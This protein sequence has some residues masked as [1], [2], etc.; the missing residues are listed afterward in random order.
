MNK[1]DLDNYI[2][3]KI[4]TN[5]TEDIT[6]NKLQDVLR[7]IN[8]S[9]ENNS[10]KG[11]P[12][13]YASLD[14]TG[15]V[16]LEQL[17]IQPPVWGDITGDLENQTDLQSALD[18]KQ[19]TLTFD[20]TPTNGSDNPVTSNGVYDALYL[21]E[22]SSNKGI[23]NGYAPLN[24]STKIDS[25]YLPSY[26]DDVVEV[27]N[28]ASLPV[29]GE[30]GK[31]YVTIDTGYIYRWSGSVY[32]KI[33]EQIQSDYTQTNT[34]A[35]DYIKN[36]PTISVGL[37]MPS[38]FNVI[39]SPT[40]NGTLTVTG[41]GTNSQYVRGDGTLGTSVSGTVTSVGL[42]MPSAFTVSNSPII[43]NGNISVTGAG[44]SS[45]YVRG[46]GVLAN[47]PTTTGGGSSVAYYL[48]G[49]VAQGTFGG[50][51]Y[52][53]LSKTPV[54]GAG[55]DFSLTNTT[56]YIAEFITNVA[57][58]S[59]LS[60]PTGAWN[61]SLYFS[62]SNNTG[63]PSFYIELYKYDG[64]TFTLIGSNS[65]S[66][67]II[68]NGT[69]IDLYTTSVAVPLTTLTITDRLAVRVF[70]NTNGNRTI[71]LHTED[72]HLCEII[73]TFSTGLN[74]IN[75]LTNQVQYLS[76]G[77]SGTDFAI[78]S[79]SDTHTF[80][81][82][83]ASSTK[84][85]KLSS[86]DWS[87]FNGKV[88]TTRSISTSSPLSGGG[89]LSAD[90]TLSIADAAADGTTK[91][92]ATF[93]ASDFNS[94]SGVISIDYTN[95]QSASNTNKGFLTSADWSTFNGKV[96][97]SLTISTTS[98]LSGGGD[99]SANRT[100]SI[101]DAAADGTTKGAATFTA[102]DFNSASGVISIDY[103][104][105]QAASAS[106]KGFLTSTDFTTF[107]GK[108]NAIT[109]TTTGTTG[110]STLVGS[111]L[112]IPQYAGGLVNFTEAQNTTSPN[113][114]VYVDSL[115]AIS[116]VTNTDF[117]II[118]KG[119]GALLAAVPDGTATGGNKRGNN[120]IDL[121]MV[122]TANTMVASGNNAIII[123]SG[124]TASGSSSSVIGRSNS[125]A[126]PDSTAVGSL[127]A[128]TGAGNIGSVAIGYNNSVSV[129]GGVALGSSNTAST[130]S[131]GYA[132]AV[133]Q[134]N[135]A[136]GTNASSIGYSNTASGNQSVAL[137]YQN[138]S[139]GRASV[140]HGSWGSSFS[141][142]ERFVHSTFGYV[143]GDS[144]KSVFL[145]SARTTNNTATTLTASFS[146]VPTPSAT[147]Q[148][149]LQNNNS[150]R[151]KGSI[152]ARQSGSTNTSAWD[153]DGIIQRGTTAASTTLLI[154]NV[155]LVQN[156]PAW[157]MP[158]LAADTTLGCLRVQVTG[159]ATTNIQW[160]CSI[161]TTEVIYA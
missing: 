13:G 17:P 130:T 140:V 5:V 158:T 152:I 39:G 114:T 59:L 104:N 135:T 105:G 61:F 110:A 67:E 160:T 27:A 92:A 99:L 106:N 153:I 77:T 15:K 55:T 46:D 119:T 126:S 32:V 73:T 40:S 79:T 1:N 124:S 85:G 90:R 9:V 63:N 132:V 97:T 35:V 107:N 50:N 141:V 103:T 157:G 71:T 161:E 116:A 70:V 2:N 36:K 33:A 155:T 91:G 115:S 51:A 56:G 60:I 19:N 23:A 29:T 148:V 38:A 133:G 88:N 25:T 24:S 100:L 149:T 82:P 6:G 21:K 131:T 123:G 147:N 76:T 159:V 58:P 16:P 45:Q 41:A 8:G 28:Y 62:S 101:S 154:S 48:N 20:T 136:S 150:F 49:S 129:N 112:N 43:S 52:K 122:R 84:T 146:Q 151:F 109:L 145:L 120:A 80:N 57:D 54:I 34:S 18:S 22:D 144:Q 75:G 47:F 12:D 83:V 72:N 143:A 81:L 69:A 108:Q 30:T 66:P 26:V 86:T 96:N 121:Q 94:T 111:T 4:Y 31:I 98:P 87:T 139:S 64:T 134:S 11:I 78:N 128:I 10:N 138:T 7:T 118:P 53:Q 93:T 102:S 37:S 95:G 89:D 117:A 156:T 44:L 127:N 14:E 3:S 42:S 142:Y 74:A 65:T 68:S 125:N 137:G 113:N